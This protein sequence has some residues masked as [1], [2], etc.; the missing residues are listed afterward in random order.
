MMLNRLY[1][2]LRGAF[3]GGFV[4]QML[5]MKLKALDRLYE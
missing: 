5:N 1:I 3:K 4:M 2:D